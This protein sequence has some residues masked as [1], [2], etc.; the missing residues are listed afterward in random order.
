[1][2]EPAFYVYAGVLLVGACCW[3]FIDPRR[4]VETDAQRE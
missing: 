1:M 3:L 2:S 4:T